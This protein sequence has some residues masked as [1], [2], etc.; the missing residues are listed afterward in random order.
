MKQYRV[1]FKRW[2]ERKPQNQMTFNEGSYALHIFEEICKI[3]PSH[4][5]NIRYVMLE[6]VEDGKVTLL[7][8]VGF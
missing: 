3:A 7:K 6:S 1:S 2:G 5:E 8:R 4:I